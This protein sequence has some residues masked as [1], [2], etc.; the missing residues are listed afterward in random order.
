MKN[1]MMSSGR[2]FLF[3]LMVQSV[4]VCHSGSTSLGQTEK[5]P[6]QDRIDILI[7]KLSTKDFGEIYS[8][9]DELIRTADGDAS[10]RSEI[11][12]KLLS[13]AS[14]DPS[15]RTSPEQ[16]NSWEGSVLILGDLRAHEA[17]DI[18]IA[19]L[20]CNDGTGSLNVAATYPAFDA[21]AKIGQPA[22]PSIENELVKTPVVPSNIRYLSVLLLLRIGGQKERQFL[23]RLLDTETDSLVK[24]EI[25][26]HL[27]NR[28]KAK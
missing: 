16:Y 21:L 9:R 24:K 17:I 8:I 23:R 7:G 20:N 1:K 28:G 13:I 12:K 19:C 27:S 6:M 15:I 14:E 26:N 22:I 10:A 4:T 3:L 18:L 5:E 2:M 25:R 11:I